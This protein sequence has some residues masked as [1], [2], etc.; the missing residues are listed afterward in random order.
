MTKTP[1]LTGAEVCVT[2]L[3]GQN[4]AVK[5]LSG[6]TVWASAFPNIT[7][8]ADGVVE[9]PAGGG[10]VVL[11]THGTIYLLG[12]G[13]VQ[14]TGTDYATPNFRQPSSSSGGGGG[15]SDVTKAYVDVQDSSTLDTAKT[16]TDT[17]VNAV[18]T[19]VT[20]NADDIADLQTDMTAAQ[21][22]ITANS[23]A[24]TSAQTAAETAQ[25][26]ASGA[27]ATA[28]T[29]KSTADAAQT[30]ADAAQAAA[31][32]NAANIT[33]TAAATLESAKTYTDTKTS[34][35]DTRVSATETA[36]NTLNGTGTGS[37]TKAVADGIADVV[38]GAP[39]SLDTLKEIS[40]WISSHSDSAAAMNTQIQT[41]STDI[42][43]LQTAKADK[44]EIPTTLPANGGN[45]DT[46]SGHTVGADVPADAVFSDTT[47]ST[48]TQTQDGLMPAT[49]KT[50]LDGVAENANNYILPA[51]TKTTLGG[52][53]VGDNLSI[54]DGTLSAPIYSNPNLLDNPDFRIN[55]RGQSTYTMEAEAY[56]VDRWSVFR[57]SISPISTGGVTYT[58][59][60][61]VE[62]G[63][64]IQVRP[65]DGIFDN[66]TVTFSACVN[67][68]IYSCTG[69]GTIDQPFTS[70]GHTF[71]LIA[72]KNSYRIRFFGSDSYSVTVSWMKL[73]L[74]SVATPFVPPSPSKEFIK[75]L[76]YYEK[77]VSTVWASIPDN[78]AFSNLLMGITF[79]MPKRIKPSI[80]L[81]ALYHNGVDVSSTYFNSISTAAVPISDLYPQ[82]RVTNGIVTTKQAPVKNDFSYKVVYEA[83]ADL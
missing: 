34:A 12:T 62:Y 57:G 82:Y 24:I 80:K 27:Q 42:S 37:V 11:D 58:Y 17:A 47:Y 69:K 29:A 6:D 50:K 40:D 3:G 53:K 31:D 70:Q 81:F 9:I 48:V 59:T 45:A 72:W 66:D 43:A 51:A 10:E 63:D 56:G 13:K 55:Q 7:V 78:S 74:G 39:E 49:D 18:K 46:V 38:A 61:G 67:G 64:I 73:E 33:S 22:A 65:A 25:T 76:Y 54:S 28:N 75:C 4:V 79:A 21:N 36:I 1:I 20:A 19:D 77:S 41:N 71:H 68:I 44:S 52:V 5:N 23:M 83:S 8:G 35:L 15:T 30:T 26:A 60:S 32:T 16:Y 2:D 14:V